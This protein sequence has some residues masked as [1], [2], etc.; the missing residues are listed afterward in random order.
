MNELYGKCRDKEQ[1]ESENQLKFLGYTTG[2]EGLENV[3]LIGHIK[4]KMHRGGESE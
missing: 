2:K 4:G 1:L 3:T